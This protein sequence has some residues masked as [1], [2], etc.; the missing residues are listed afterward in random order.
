MSE[1]VKNEALE[2]SYYFSEMF[3][4]M[5]CPY[6]QERNKLNL[7]DINDYTAPDVEDCQ[8][9]KCEKK[10]WLPDNKQ[11]HL[12]MHGIDLDEEI[13]PKELG[14]KPGDDLIEHAFCEKGK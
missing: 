11:L 8:C 3:V 14:L 2:A 6:C 12:D 5:E 1:T 4:I 7:G 13:S 9:K 10:F